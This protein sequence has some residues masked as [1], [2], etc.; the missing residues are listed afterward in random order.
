M[1]NVIMIGTNN[2]QILEDGGFVVFGGS[3]GR[4]NHWD[5]DWNHA[6]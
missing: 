6:I 5:W 4:E 3:D 1:K 2:A